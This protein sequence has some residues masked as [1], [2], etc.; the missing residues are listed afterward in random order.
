[1]LGGDVFDG[2]LV[3]E[4]FLKA[5]NGPRGTSAFECTKEM[6]SL[7]QICISKGKLM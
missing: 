6:N 7:S 5:V 3:S 2:R 1:V 4:L